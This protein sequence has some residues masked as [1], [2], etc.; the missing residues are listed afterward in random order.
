MAPASSRSTPVHRI[1]RAVAQAHLGARREA[2][3]AGRRR[4]GEVAALDPQVAP[5]RQAARERGAFGRRHVVRPQRRVEVER[6]VEVV[7]RQPDRVRHGEHARRDRVEVVAHDVVVKRQLDAA[8]DGRDAGLVAEAPQRLGADAAAPLPGD[9]RHARVVPARDVALGHEAEQ[10][11]LAHHRVVQVEARELVL[12]VARLRDADRVQVP[13]VERAVDVELERADRVR[14]ALDGVGLAVGPVVERVDR[15]RVAA[16]VV[17]RVAADAVHQRV[18]QLHVRVRHH[19]VLRVDPGAEDERAV[20]VLAAAHLVEEAQVLLDGAV[21]ER[22]WASGLRHG[23]AARADLVLGL[24]VDEREAVLDEADGPRVKLLEV[25]RREADLRRGEAQ[26][27]HG[28]LEGG[29]VLGGLR[30]GVGVVVAEHARAAE[31]AREA[32]V[33][34]DRLGV[35]EV[36]VAVGLRREAR[37]DAPA[38]RVGGDVAGDDVAEEVGGGGQVL[39]GHRGAAGSAGRYRRRSRGASRPAWGRA[40]DGRTAALIRR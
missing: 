5:E 19:A 3:P 24:L 36:R 37:R 17:V 38:V 6:R 18:A 23:P 15:P 10:L 12:V 33:E 16:A 13:V 7:D 40:E 22:A 2:L 21:A 35:P 8:V 4:L 20:R 30:F 26:P 11:A 28:V 27:P 32:E 29:D 34:A 25:V 31:V 9:R 14:D 1:D 39:R